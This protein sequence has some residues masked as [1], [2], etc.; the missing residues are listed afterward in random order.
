[1]KQNYLFGGNALVPCSTC[2]VKKPYNK[3]FFRKSSGHRC[4]VC[5]KEYYANRH[6]RLYKPKVRRNP[7]DCK[8][9]YGLTVG[10]ANEIYARGCELCGSDKRLCIDHNHETGKVRG[11]LCSGCNTLVGFIERKWH[12]LGAVAE[13][14]KR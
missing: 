7:D 4:L 13:W 14:I 11:C 6:K 9:A 2:G 12:L 5:E 8:F 3:E 1:M 10:E